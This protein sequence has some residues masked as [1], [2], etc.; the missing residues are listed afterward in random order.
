M[1]MLGN[2]VILDRLMEA[3]KGHDKVHF[4]LSQPVWQRTS[5]VV[6]FDLH[7]AVSTQSSDTSVKVIGMLGISHKQSKV[8]CSRSLSLSLSL[9]LRSL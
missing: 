4:F 6:K 1:A 5:T 9:S 7:K 2:P 8:K 3:H